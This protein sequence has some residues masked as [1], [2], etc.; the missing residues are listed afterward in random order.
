MEG[1]PHSFRYLNL[2]SEI[3]RCGSLVWLGVWAVCRVME[4]M[5]SQQFVLSELMAVPLYPFTMS[6]IK[7]IFSSVDD[8]KHRQ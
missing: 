8:T 6:H 4:L 2:C 3:V 7:E 5:L 1:T